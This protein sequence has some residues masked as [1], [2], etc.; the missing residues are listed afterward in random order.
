[1]F[2]LCK[3]GISDSIPVIPVEASV[4]DRFSDV[5]RGNRFRPIEIG[6]RT[7]HFQG[8]PDQLPRAYH[9][10]AF[11]DLPDVQMHVPKR[12]QLDQ[13]AEVINDLGHSVDRRGSPKAFEAA[14]R[15][16]ACIAQEFIKDLLRVRNCLDFPNSREVECLTTRG[17]ARGLADRLLAKEKSRLHHADRH[18]ANRRRN[19]ATR[20]FKCTPN[21]V[22]AYSRLGSLRIAMNEKKVTWVEPNGTFDFPGEILW[23]VAETAPVG[24]VPVD[25]R[26]NSALTQN[27]TQ[28]WEECPVRASVRNQGKAHFRHSVS[29]IQRFLK[30]LPIRDTRTVG[31]IA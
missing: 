2:P 18:N 27:P 24:P 23:R 11:C 19:G 25:L 21:L 14:P 31:T 1:M 8:F 30:I 26:P 29:E 3:R 17:V 6:H 7:R 12:R 16:A 9:P 22:F 10:R 4:L 28:D 13:W 15:K 20:A 5:L